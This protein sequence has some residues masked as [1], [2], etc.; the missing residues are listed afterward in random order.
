MIDHQLVNEEESSK[1]QSPD[2]SEESENDNA[3]PKRPKKKGKKVIMNVA[4]TKYQVVKKTASK[5][6]GWKL[7]KKEDDENWDIFWTD[8]SVEPEKL[9]RMKIYQKINHFP[10]MY[11]LTRKNHLAKNL[12]RMRKQLPEVYNYYPK[13]WLVPA[14]LS[15]LRLYSSKEKNQVFIV[16]P[17]ASC[18]GRGIFLT[19]KFDDFSF[20]DRYVVQEYIKQPFLIDGLKFDLRIYVLVAGC[21]PLRIYLH[22]EGLGRFATEPYSQ[23]NASNLAK[24]CMHLTNYAINKNNENFVFNENEED[25]GVGHKR[26]LT[27]IMKY[28]E[29]S[30]HNTEK[31]WNEIKAM[32]VNT[33]IAAQPMLSHTYRACQPDDPSNSMCFEILGLDVMLDST[34]KPWLLEVNHSPSFTT[35]SPLDWKIKFEV[36]SQ[37]LTLMNISYSNRK[38]AES[39]R[40]K[41]IL[42][43]S[44]TTSQEKKEIKQHEIRRAQRK[45]DIW[46]QNNIG[47]YTKIYPTANPKE[48]EKIFETSRQVYEEWAGYKKVNKKE[49]K[50]Q[51]LNRPKSQLM[52]TK[53]S[54]FQKKETDCQNQRSMSIIMCNTE[55][56]AIAEGLVRSSTP[57]VYNRL[58]SPVKRTYKNEGLQ[59]NFPMVHLDKSHQSEVPV[60]QS[61]IIETSSQNNKKSQS[62][63]RKPQNSTIEDLINESKAIENLKKRLIYYNSPLKIQSVQL[64]HNSEDNSVNI[65]EFQ[66]LQIPKIKCPQIEYIRKQ[67]NNL[68]NPAYWKKVL[69]RL[70]KQN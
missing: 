23:P 1:T 59:S 31:L 10:G 52:R 14:E 3:M 20:D 45:R 36:I 29:D 54:G 43:R 69:T 9:A 35:D 37:A 30:G 28:L 21:D 18:Q 48:Y 4:L 62:P 47:G 49:E 46:E 60:R 64:S 2:K 33:L 5:F 42:T 50:A 8:A 12:N 15:D 57:C 6:F 17:E 39:K 32:I 51:E 26:S 44:L 38:T 24:P 53:A 67:S 70:E 55:S 63:C 27:S 11:A 66:D 40:K 25:D 41:S 34:L 68:R 56:E 22:K 61:L 13:T 7:T 58:Y 16:K 65:S 19:K